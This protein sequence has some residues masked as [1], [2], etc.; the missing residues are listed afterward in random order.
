MKPETKR[1][2]DAL[3]G[4]GVQPVQVRT[5]RMLGGTTATIFDEDDITVVVDHS[6]A[7][8]A[9]GYGVLI[10]RDEHTVPYLAVVTTD[11]RRAGVR[12]VAAAPAGGAR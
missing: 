11:P 10:R 9:D 7:L 8:V 4:I 1:L 2:R 12:D 6:A 3:S 5:D